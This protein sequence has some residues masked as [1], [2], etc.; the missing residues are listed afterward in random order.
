[1]GL[2]DSDF[3]PNGSIS[4]QQISPQ[5]K[6]SDTY[7]GELVLA[8]QKTGQTVADR[9]REDIFEGPTSKLRG[10]RKKG[11]KYGFNAYL[12]FTGAYDDSGFLDVVNEIL[13]ADGL[14]NVADSISN[15]RFDDGISVE[16]YDKAIWS[17]GPDLYYHENGFDPATGLPYIGGV[18]MVSGGMS[19]RRFILAEHGPIIET[20][21]GEV[22]YLPVTDP[23]MSGWKAEG[24]WCTFKQGSQEKYFWSMDP[25][26]STAPT[27]TQSISVFPIVSLQDNRNN[28]FP[29]ETLPWGDNR[30]NYRRK[31]IR[32][33]G[34]DFADMSKEVFA[35][36]PDFGT[37][38]WQ[39]TYGRQYRGTQRLIDRY[40]T[41]KDYYDFLKHKV[42]IPPYGSSD[43]NS[44][45]G[46]A[47]RDMKEECARGVSRPGYEVLPTTKKF[48]ED[49][50][51]EWD[52][53]VG[54]V[55]D[56]QKA[57]ENVKNITDV[58][59]GI[60]ASAKTLNASN[61]V[62]LYYTLEP[63]MKLMSLVPQ[64][65]NPNS[66]PAGNTKDNYVYEMAFTVAPEA[67]SMHVVYNF[68]DWSSCRR[69]GVA[70]E[71]VY[72][73]GIK[74]AK[75]K[76]GDFTID[77]NERTPWGVDHKYRTAQR[78]S[79]FIGERAPDFIDNPRPD[80][81]WS[82][83]SPTT[84][85]LRVQDRPDASGRPRYLELRLYDAAAMH[86]VDVQRDGEHGKSGKVWIAGGLDNF[87]VED[88]DAPYSDVLLFPLGVD[89]VDKV[90]LF[91]RERLLRESCMLI[92][93]TIQMAEVKWYQQGWFQIVITVVALLLTAWFAPAGQVLIT[94]LKSAAVMA[95]LYV[96]SKA[97]T[98]PL[99]LAIVSIAAMVVGAYTPGAGLTM[100]LTMAVE[101]AG[102]VV[103]T[104]IAQDVIK[105]Q[106]EIK[107]FK[108]MVNEKQK[109]IEK[110]Q[111]EAGMSDHNADWMLYVASLA[112][113]E[114]PE[115]FFDRA[116]NTEMCN[117]DVEYMVD[118]DARLPGTKS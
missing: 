114:D 68:G 87:Y 65:V 17:R 95:V 35:W 69:Y 91:K 64:S 9:I 38:E 14:G 96:A 99:L 117:S 46:K 66:G 88:D 49:Y 77:A 116:L 25:R 47:F 112:P 107:E 61:V 6:D 42:E 100:S 10:F 43:W 115:E 101:A 3:Q 113:T 89:A 12:S 22:V 24:F 20:T 48:C 7:F 40:D 71:I 105:L 106:K 50:A 75:Y 73:P 2:F 53:Y 21:S 44:D 104:K 79:S 102:I 19:T 18:N 27:H 85:E 58:H 67:G 82:Y 36:I 4:N 118:V 55:D 92:I 8:N 51:T 94:V 28:E 16:M 81:D 41:E 62:A 63:V 86:Y 26:F 74:N 76:H 78:D 60:M 33:L 1:M 37:A 90:P 80:P 110:M 39:M 93:G 34:V 109:E 98:N 70:D 31:T 103:Q 13:T 59:F 5:R 83:V 11:T 108:E 57:G 32:T 23:D 111:N 54:M 45:Y 30:Y 84:L 29:Y 56:K 52:Y 72:P 15:Y 97:I